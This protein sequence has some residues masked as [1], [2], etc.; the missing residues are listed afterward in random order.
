MQNQKSRHL[1]A[2]DLNLHII[3]VQESEAH[4]PLLR[5]LKVKLA[6]PKSMVL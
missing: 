5:P 6:Q 4:H 3:Y 2:L 1:T